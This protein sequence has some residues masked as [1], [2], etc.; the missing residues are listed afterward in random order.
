MQE[1]HRQWSYGKEGAPDCA[2]VDM[3]WPEDRTLR[4]QAERTL[5][6]P[7]WSI[8]ICG[9]ISSKFTMQ[10]HFLYIPFILPNHLFFVW[11]CFERQLPISKTVCTHEAIFTNSH[12]QFASI[13]VL[14][15]Q[16]HPG[17]LLIIIKE[18]EFCRIFHLRMERK[19]DA[20]YRSGSQ[21]A[22]SEVEIGVQYIYRGVRKAGLGKGISWAVM[23]P[24]QRP[25]P[26][27]QLS[28]GAW[29]ALQSCPQLE[30]RGQGFILW[31]PPYQAVM[32]YRL[33]QEIE[34]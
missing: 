27:P 5:F 9:R 19:E 17:E 26:S 33:P 2:A 4:K 22:D 23:Q 3:G 16:V 10:H 14:T 24:Q 31:I 18:K 1:M 8:C 32:G 29:L 7:T 12:N 28:S 13:L 30:Q 20:Y 6:F 15:S 25:Q 34:M 21:E 11:L